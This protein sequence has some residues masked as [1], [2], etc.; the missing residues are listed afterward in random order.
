MINSV[1][2]TRGWEYFL[3]CL[4]LVKTENHFNFHFLLQ[5]IVV[6]DMRRLY[7][8]Q[9]TFL[10]WI[11]VGPA[12]SQHRLSHYITLVKISLINI[13]PT[14]GYYSDQSCWSAKAYTGWSLVLILICDTAH[15]NAKVSTI[16]SSFLKYVFLSSGHIQIF[17]L[18]I[19]YILYRNNSIIYKNLCTGA[20][21]KT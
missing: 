21:A 9:C 6:R 15:Y 14:A 10:W 19:I 1:L 11:L 18:F 2:D 12:D 17:Y 5:T 4:C 8:D 3:A 20:W 16:G 13:K 7:N